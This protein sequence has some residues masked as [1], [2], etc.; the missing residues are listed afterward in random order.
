MNTY[1]HEQIWMAASALV[2]HI[3]WQWEHTFFKQR[4]YRAYNMLTR[5]ANLKYIQQM[6]N[7]TLRL[8]EIF[9]ALK[10]SFSYNIK[11]IG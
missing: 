1:F 2:G 9:Y 10:Y 8:E 6:T 7:V 4:F 5:T 3:C 11:N